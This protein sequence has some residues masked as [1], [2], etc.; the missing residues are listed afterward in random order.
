[1][2]MSALQL[3]LNPTPST[4]LINE[5]TATVKYYRDRSICIADSIPTTYKTLINSYHPSPTSHPHQKF[6]QSFS[7]RIRRNSL[8]TDFIK[9][10]DIHFRV[11]SG[12]NCDS[13]KDKNQLAF[14]FPGK[15]TLD[16]VSGS[17]MPS[18]GWGGIILLLGDTPVIHAPVYVNPTFPRNT[19]SLRATKSYCGYDES[20]HLSLIHI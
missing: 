8:T 1:M 18:I 20:I 13:V 2:A 15:C 6:L 12:A 4:S 7:T 14:Y 11:D 17:S 16:Q 19:F 9:H 3:Y 5:P 10:C